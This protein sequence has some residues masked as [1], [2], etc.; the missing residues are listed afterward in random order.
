MDN[1]LNKMKP[2]RGLGLEG[3]YLS[4]DMNALTG[5]RHRRFMSIENA[6]TNKLEYAVGV[7]YQ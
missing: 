3:M 7:S 5:I 6:I 4:I 2:L 1:R